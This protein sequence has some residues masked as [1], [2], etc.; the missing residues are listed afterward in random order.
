MSAPPSPHG[1][2]EMSEVHSS[3]WSSGGPSPPSAEDE[4]I[5]AA[6]CSQPADDSPAQSASRSQAAVCISMQP[7]TPLPSSPSSPPSPPP[8]EVP[9]PGVLPPEPG[10]G[11]G[12]PFGVH[13]P[14]QPSAGS[15][16]HPVCIEPTQ[17]WSSASVKPLPPE[18]RPWQTSAASAVHRAGS[19]GGVEQLASC[20]QRA[21]YIR[22]QASSRGT[23]P[24]P[25]V[26]PSGVQASGRVPAIASAHAS[27]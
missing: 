9:P 21:S 25:W 7:S 27:E 17:L 4:Q 14:Q 13:G 26:P 16:A 2:S 23:P 18:P 11:P 22:S 3:T 1:I 10:P 20:R 12:G 5:T 24:G 19:P 15:P 6:S 8:D